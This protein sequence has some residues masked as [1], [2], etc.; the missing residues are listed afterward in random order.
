MAAWHGLSFALDLYDVSVLDVLT[1]KKD[2]LGKVC[3]NS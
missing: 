1:S 2:R 3:S